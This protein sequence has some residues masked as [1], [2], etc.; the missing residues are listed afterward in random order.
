MCTRGMDTC[1]DEGSKHA[2]IWDAIVY[3]MHF[4]TFQTTMHFSGIVR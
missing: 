2:V 3:F 1:Q 4:E